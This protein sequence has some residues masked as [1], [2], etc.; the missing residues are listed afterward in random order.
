MAMDGDW[1]CPLCARRKRGRPPAR[2]A[3]DEQVSNP[4]RARLLSFWKTKVL[5]AQMRLF[6]IASKGLY[7]H[8]GDDH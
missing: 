7:M 6:S 8:I 1:A 3:A 5:K 4:S 2:L